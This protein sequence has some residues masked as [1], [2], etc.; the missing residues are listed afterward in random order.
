MKKK[1]V[2]MLSRV[3]MVIAVMYAAAPC[4]GKYYEPEIPKELYK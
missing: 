3:L 4:H 1:I 2:G